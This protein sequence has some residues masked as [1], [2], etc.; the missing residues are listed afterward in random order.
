M[1]SGPTVHT[2]KPHPFINTQPLSFS[3]STPLPN[4]LHKHSEENEA[5]DSCE[6]GLPESELCLDL[7]VA[8]AGELWL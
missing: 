1:S 7:G 6:H 8:R 3:F 4:H 5:G 2:L